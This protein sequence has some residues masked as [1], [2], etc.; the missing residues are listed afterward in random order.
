MKFQLLE[1]D[2]ADTQIALISEFN[3][4]NLLKGKICPVCGS[5]FLVEADNDIITG[6]VKVGRDHYLE[7]SHKSC[8]TNEFN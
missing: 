2:L 1:K 8:L 3:N 4:V 5:G 6:K 7:F